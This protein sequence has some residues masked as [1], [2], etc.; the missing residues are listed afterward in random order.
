[1]TGLLDFAQ[2]HR[3]EAAHF[4][5]LGVFSDVT[6]GYLRRETKDYKR[7]LIDEE[8]EVLSLVGTISSQG[9]TP[10]V[11]AHVTVSKA[12]GTAHGGHLLEAHVWPT[13][14]VIVEVVS[15]QLKQAHDPKTGLSLIR[16]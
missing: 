3:I 4:M 5:A 14:E 6:F 13:L 2:Q 9:G 1:M 7:I 10:I 8:V 16:L 11:H 12:D 15:D